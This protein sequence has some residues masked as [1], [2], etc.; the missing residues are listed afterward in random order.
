MSNCIAKQRGD[1]QKFSDTR[2]SGCS[3]TPHPCVRQVPLSES[4]FYVFTFSRVTR[5]ASTHAEN[6]ALTKDFG[7]KE[8]IKENGFIVE[9]NMISDTRRTTFS[10]I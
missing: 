3:R 6:V 5:F 2:G 9:N 1:K 7:L 10:P 8:R 4:R